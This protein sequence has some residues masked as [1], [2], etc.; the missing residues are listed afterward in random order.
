MYLESVL[1]SVREQ[2]REQTN[3]QST[4]NRQ[5]TQA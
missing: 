5:Q 3:T 2:E 4:S 1:L